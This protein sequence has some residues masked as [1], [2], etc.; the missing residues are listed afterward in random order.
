MSGVSKDTQLC[1]V[2]RG[3]PRYALKKGTNGLWVLSTSK[4]KT[5]KGGLLRYDQRA[6][7][8]KPAQFKVIDDIDYSGNQEPE[9]CVRVLGWCRSV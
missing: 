5:W 9:G 8:M 4:R 1:T 3:I 2:V 6:F 7:V